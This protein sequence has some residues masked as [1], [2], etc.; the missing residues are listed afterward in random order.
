MH[1]TYNLENANKNIDRRRQSTHDILIGSGLSLALK[2]AERGG[3][4]RTLLLWSDACRMVVVVVGGTMLLPVCGAGL[5]AKKEISNKSENAT[6]AFY[7]ET[8]M[9]LSRAGFENEERHA[10][11]THQPLQMEPSQHTKLYCG[12]CSQPI[13]VI[14]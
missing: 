6:K 11:F 13:F 12:P 4:E 2:V 3:G 1:K 14:P 8:D 10:T 9:R 7:S 5:E